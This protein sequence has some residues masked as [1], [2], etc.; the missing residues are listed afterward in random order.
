MMIIALSPKGHNALVEGAIVRMKRT[1][2]PARYSFAINSFEAQKYSRG[3]CHA[4]RG[5][6]SSLFGAQKFQ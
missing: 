4:L 6:W 5:V 2:I 3:D 1:G